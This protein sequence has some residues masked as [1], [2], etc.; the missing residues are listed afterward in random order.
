MHDA[1]SLTSKGTCFRLLLHLQFLVF[2]LLKLWPHRNHL[3]LQFSSAQLIDV[4]HKRKFDI[5]NAAKLKCIQNKSIHKYFT[6]AD[7]L[8]R[9]HMT[10]LKDFGI[11]RLFFFVKEPDHLNREVCRETADFGLKCKNIMSEFILLLH[12][13][14][15]TWTKE[16]FSKSED[17]AY[18]FDIEGISL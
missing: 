1:F 15:N 7:S 4:Q 3:L 18:R 2:N 9:L 6:Y 17:K 16:H 14:E 12:R 13:R 8:Q 11:H 10:Y 5:L